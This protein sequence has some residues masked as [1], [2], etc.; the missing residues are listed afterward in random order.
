MRFVFLQ[1]LAFYFPDCGKIP[2]PVIQV[3]GVSFRYASNK[4]GTRVI[5]SGPVA[6]RHPASSCKRL[7]ISRTTIWYLHH[8]NANSNLWYCKPG[9]H[10]WTH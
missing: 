7:K 6:R 5:R 9:F 1:T 10:A 2:P 4:V 8:E 3:Q